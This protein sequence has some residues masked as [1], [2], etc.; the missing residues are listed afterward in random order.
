MLAHGR[1]QRLGQT[2]PG[3]DRRE[4]QALQEGMVLETVARAF[5]RRTGTALAAQARAKAATAERVRVTNST[6]EMIRE[7]AASLG[8]R[9]D[10]IEVPRTVCE[11]RWLVIEA[12]SR[13]RV[14]EGTERGPIVSAHGNP[15]HPWVGWAMM[16]LPSGCPGTGAT[17]T[18]HSPAC[19]TKAGASGLW[20]GKV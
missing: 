13:L 1:R 19:P 4:G 16:L 7:V 3:T 9:K 11:H 8:Q 20:I 6:E 10:A 17:A 14:V 18:P 5:A 2:G 15:P 12:A